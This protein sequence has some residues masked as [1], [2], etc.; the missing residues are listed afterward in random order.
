MRRVAI[1]FIKFQSSSDEWARTWETE[2][3]IFIKEYTY[4]YC[5]F[6]AY[7]I[8]TTKKNI[9]KKEEITV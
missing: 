7:C 2:E 1:G 8:Y 9:N 6:A 4:Y 5:A 3:A